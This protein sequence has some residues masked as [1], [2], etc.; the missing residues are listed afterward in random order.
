MPQ[1]QV[2]FLGGADK[3]KACGDGLLRWD[4][5]GPGRING[6]GGCASGGGGL[7]SHPPIYQGGVGGDGCKAGGGCMERRND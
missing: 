3:L 5:R 1:A 6:L 4:G 2:Y 7:L